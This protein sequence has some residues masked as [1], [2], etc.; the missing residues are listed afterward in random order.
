M[1]DDGIDPG[2]RHAV[3]VGCGGGP[4]WPGLDA[5]E[6]GVFGRETKTRTPRATNARTNGIDCEYRPISTFAPQLR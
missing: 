6:D 5:R 2:V 4:P 3:H 1:T